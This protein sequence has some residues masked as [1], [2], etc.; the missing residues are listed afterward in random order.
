MCSSDLQDLHRRIL[1]SP[2]GSEPL[3]GWAKHQPAQPVSLIIGPEGGLTDAE[4]NA[5]IAHGALCLHLGKRVLRTETA[6]L[7]SIAAL[8][9]VWGEL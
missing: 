3:T 5:A 6:G 8:Q 7:A 9:A 2:R 1:L 4:E